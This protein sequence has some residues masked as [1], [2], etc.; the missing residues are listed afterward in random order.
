MKLIQISVIGA[1][2]AAAWEREATTDKNSYVAAYPDISDRYA[3]RWKINDLP[4][5]LL[6]WQKLIFYGGNTPH[7]LPNRRVSVERCGRVR[8]TRWQLIRKNKIKYELITKW[9]MTL[10]IFTKK[11]LVKVHSCPHLLCVI[12]SFFLGYDR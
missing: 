10:Q 11:P 7:A 3:P 12:L 4:A 5:H 6:A 9:S 8:M 2:F 1:D